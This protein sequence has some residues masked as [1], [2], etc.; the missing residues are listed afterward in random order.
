MFAAIARLDIRFRW[1][2]VAVWLVGVVAGGRLLPGLTSVT[3]ASN[4]Q[5]LPS[6]SPSEQATRLAAPFQVV[7]PNQTATIVASRA[8]GQLTAADAAAISQIEQA[9]RQ[10]PGVAS[11][12]D[13]GTSPD[14]RAAQAVVTVPGSVSSSNASATDAVHRIRA[15]MAHSGVPPGLGL[16]LTGPLAVSADARNTETSGITRFTL[17]FVIVV[18]FVVYRA[19]APW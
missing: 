6:S 17:L 19:L 15:A 4:G 3:H 8:S 1:L 13:V 2:I 12:R 16:H 5:F 14:G 7:D 18:L 10:V 11:V 9:V